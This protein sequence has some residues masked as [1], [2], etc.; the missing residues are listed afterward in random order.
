MSKTPVHCG[1]HEL[2]NV[3]ESLENLLI[4]G[5]KQLLFSVPSDPNAW[6]LHPWSQQPRAE[7]RQRVHLLNT[8]EGGLQGSCSETSG[9]GHRTKLCFLLFIALTEFRGALGNKMGCLF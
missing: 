2:Q 3:P 5:E 6:K 4:P 8:W 7:R 1:S 9:P